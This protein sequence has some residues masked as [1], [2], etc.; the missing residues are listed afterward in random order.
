V[1]HQQDDHSAN[2]CH[3][4]AVQIDPRDAVRSEHTEKV[5]AD[6]RSNYAK[7]YFLHEVSVDVSPCLQSLAVTF[8]LAGQNKSRDTIAALAES[9]ELSY[10]PSVAP[11]L[12]SA[13]IGDR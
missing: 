2:H 9:C 12:P 4:Q 11:I 3:K 6:D 7:N 8:P 5:S 1:I 10:Y 13:A